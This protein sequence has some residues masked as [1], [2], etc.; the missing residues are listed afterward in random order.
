M[1]ALVKSFCPVLLVALMAT[2]LFVSVQ[3]QEHSSVPCAVRGGPSDWLK[4]NVSKLKARNLNDVLHLPIK[5]HTLGDDQG[6]G[7]YDQFKLFESLCQLN[8]DFGPYD[9]Q[10]YLAGEVNKI[11]RTRY[12]D[13]DNFSDADRMM[14]TY[15]E[16]NVIN[17]YVTNNAPLEACGYWLNI[18][19]GIVVIKRCMGKD[20]HTLTHEIGHY[21]ALLHPFSGW[22]G[23][24]YESGT[25]AP[26]F[27]GVSGR[28][29]LFVELLDGSNCNVA[30][31]LICDTGP[32]YFSE[33]WPCNG[34]SESLVE[35]TDPKGNDFKIDGTNFMSYSNDPCQSRFTNEQANIMHQFAQDQKSALLDQT[36]VEEN[37]SD[38]PITNLT[39]ADGA[40]V[41]PQS[42]TLSWEAKP[43]ATHYLIQISRFSFFAVIDY[44]FI[45]DKS[46]INIGD[47]PVDK[48]YFWRVMPYNAFDVCGTFSQATGGFETT[49]TTQLHELTDNNSLQIYP[50][51]VKQEHD[52]LI[53]FSFSAPGDVEILLWDEQGKRVIQW[54][55]RYHSKDQIALPA[56]SLSSGIYTLMVVTSAGTVHQRIVKL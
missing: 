18:R 41:K 7:H 20:A 38:A 32:D 5:F 15:N 49:E 46:S 48:S 47:L 42:I 1:K 27:H 16:R 23:K 39:P 29:T 30:G 6:E 14:S 12:Y 56:A 25:T 19:D 37:L 50:T 22:E 21:L 53:D 45:S 17:V 13:H 34:D 52:V 10:F 2:T 24:D 4:Q 28:D 43:N 3:G 8:Q 35:L 36:D 40:K 26:L 55:R 33:G 54:S 9:L 11:N 31:D 44:Q 51:L